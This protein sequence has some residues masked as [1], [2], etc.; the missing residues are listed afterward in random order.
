MGLVDPAHRFRVSRV[1]AQL[2]GSIGPAYVPDGHR[3]D[4]L[5]LDPARVIWDEFQRFL[6]YN[7]SLF[8]CLSTDADI[9]EH[10]Q[11]ESVHRHPRSGQMDAPDIVI[12]HLPGY[13]LGDQTNIVITDKNR[14]RRPSN[15]GILRLR[16]NDWTQSHVGDFEEFGRTLFLRYWDRRVNGVR[17]KL[18]KAADDAKAAKKARKAAKRARKARRRANRKEAIRQANARR[19]AK[20]ISARMELVDRVHRAVS[21]WQSH[22]VPSERTSAFPNIVCLDQMCN[23]LEATIRQWGEGQGDE[24]APISKVEKWG[25]IEMPRRYDSFCDLIAVAEADLKALRD[26]FVYME[27]NRARHLREIEEISSSRRMI[28]QS[29]RE[30]QTLRNEV[31]TTRAAISMLNDRAQ[32]TQQ[33]IR[34]YSSDIDDE[35]ALRHVEGILSTIQGNSETL[36]EE[37]ETVSRFERNTLGRFR[38]LRHEVDIAVKLLKLP[39][40]YWWDEEIE[41]GPDLQRMVREWDA[42]AQRLMADIGEARGD[43]EGRSRKAYLT[44]RDDHYALLNVFKE[45]KDRAKAILDANDDRLFGRIRGVFPEH[46]FGYIM[47][48]VGGDVR[49]ETSD[50]IGEAVNGGDEVRYAV[51]P[52]QGRRVRYTGKA[53]RVELIPPQP[54]S[55]RSSVR[56]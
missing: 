4:Q 26:H 11:I 2:R 39:D 27:E 3:V 46:Q 8:H 5:P 9:R 42:H 21:E 24:R 30:Y 1:H 6:I 55:W 28:E 38:N 10:C 35:D 32:D 37:S 44:G 33:A 22:R 34:R 14:I 25:G 13:I 15:S 7:A 19:R 56:N 20:M 54:P 40:D 18:E 53:V 36:T 49:F 52:H 23:N 29:S 16:I 31:H 43:W 17:R 48:K 50:V 45:A 47:Q 41:R 51:I 12:K